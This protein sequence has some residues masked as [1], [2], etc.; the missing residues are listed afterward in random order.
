M[1]G[2]FRPQPF[3]EFTLRSPFNDTSLMTTENDFLTSA[4]PIFF[5]IDSPHFYYNIII[6]K[7]HQLCQYDFLKMKKGP[8]SF[9]SSILNF[10]LLADAGPPGYEPAVRLR[11][12][13][14]GAERGAEGENAGRKAQSEG[15]AKRPLLGI[16]GRY[17]GGR[18]RGLKIPPE[19]PAPASLPAGSKWELKSPLEK[20]GFRGI[21]TGLEYYQ[22]PVE[23]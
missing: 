12:L 17:R 6:N 1:I 13:A 4:T 14:Q 8:P 9:R 23:N 21:S 2:L 22:V 18:P 15:V 11:R 7:K 10:G 16:I 20:G 19:P 5:A 3:A